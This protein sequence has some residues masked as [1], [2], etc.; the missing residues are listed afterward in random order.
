VPIVTPGPIVLSTPLA[1]LPRDSPRV[2][3][4]LLL[5][6]PRT[7]SRAS[8]LPR[9]RTQLGTCVRHRTW[10]GF[11]S[12]R[13]TLMAS[14]QCSLETMRRGTGVNPDPVFK[15]REQEC[16]VLRSQERLRSRSAACRGVAVTVAVRCSTSATFKHLRVILTTEADR[17]APAEQM[18]FGVVGW[19]RR[20]ER[21]AKSTAL[22]RGMDF[23]L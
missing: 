20:T 9:A 1:E 2:E 22:P 10:S 17:S 8:V 16:G 13:Q 12:L 11:F 23:Q 5:H 19:G 15:E 4:G 3:A 6:R 7:R 14:G 21:T 18:D